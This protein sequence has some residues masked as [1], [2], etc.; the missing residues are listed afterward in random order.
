MFVNVF[1]ESIKQK[2]HALEEDIV[3]R[4]EYSGWDDEVFLVDDFS[5]KLTKVFMQFVEETL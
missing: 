4:D 2:S 3:E 5:V 1:V